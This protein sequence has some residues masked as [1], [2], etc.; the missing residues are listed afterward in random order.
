MSLWSDAQPHGG[1]AVEVVVEEHDRAECDV[2]QR[3]RGV[4]VQHPHRGARQLDVARTWQQRHR[5]HTVV[6]QKVELGW[7]ELLLPC[8]ALVYAGQCTPQK[9]L[10]HRLDGRTALRRRRCPSALI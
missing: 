5:A 6:P 8:H 2:H 1:R 3:K 9:W 10:R 4:T 7:R